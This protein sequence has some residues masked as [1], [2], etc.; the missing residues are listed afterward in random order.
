MD[1][2]KHEVQR[3]KERPVMGVAQ[4]PWPLCHSEL[5]IGFSVP[6]MGS[7]LLALCARMLQEGPWRGAG[8]GFDA[9]LAGRSQ[10]AGDGASRGTGHTTG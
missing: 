2:S 9:A 4:H 10:G 7:G 8:S 1:S 6:L 5:C 3:G